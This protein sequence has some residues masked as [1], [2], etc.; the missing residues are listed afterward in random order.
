MDIMVRY[1]QTKWKLY[2]QQKDY[3]LQESIQAIP[4]S[5]DQ[6]LMLDINGDM[7]VD[8]FGPSINGDSM[9][10]VNNGNGEFNVT[11]NFNLTS[12]LTYP[13]NAAFVD[14]NGDC[15]SDIVFVNNNSQIE[16]WIK[17]NDGYSQDRIINIPN[18]SSLLTFH[19][20]NRDGFIDISFIDHN[21]NSINILY[22][23]QIHYCGTLELKNC[24][25][26]SDLCT[27]SNY[28]FER[29]TIYLDPS[30]Q[31]LSIFQ[32]NQFLIPYS[33][34]T[35]DVFLD[36]YPVM[37]LVLENSN[38]TR[39][40]IW[41]SNSLDGNLRTF[42][43]VDQGV[44]ALTSNQNPIYSF[45]Y[46]FD[47]SGTLGMITVNLD[48]NTRKISYKATLNNYFSDG[49]FF[50]LLGL[51]GVSS[52]FFDKNIYGVNMPGLASKLTTTDLT[53]SKY[54]LASVQLSK[55]AYFSLETPYSHYGLG[56]TAG[57]IEE[58]FMGLPSMNTHY[59]SG[60]I[61]NSQLVVIP[62]VWEIEMY[63]SVTGAFLWV[64]LA[65]VISL[66]L[67]GMPIIIF[68]IIEKRQDDREKIIKASQLSNVFL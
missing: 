3:T 43:K 8:L 63:V 49:F 46:D 68:M 28:T 41:E 26:Y 22:N 4:E 6:L 1:N 45:F 30:T 10:W 62:L 33:I 40:E 61:P 59:W 36:S 14:I 32:F 15:A 37:L 23:Q 39:V 56:R 51:N 11:K 48:T 34:R 35:G 17:Q 60:I 5:A 2:I 25:S 53:G 9:F 19:D 47:E 16:I 27:P 24:R 64:C 42:Q 50:K 44:D 54:C 66:I 21:N 65:F 7:R 55:S 57:Y 31:K 29:V 18:N 52:S 13:L 12:K 67:L 38:Q 20:L 58:L